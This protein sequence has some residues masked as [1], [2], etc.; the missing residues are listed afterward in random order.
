MKAIKM[1]GYEP[2]LYAASATS[3][4]ML[5]FGRFWAPDAFVAFGCRKKKIALLNALERVRG[6]K[7]S[8]FDVVLPLEA[9]MA[10]AKQEMRRPVVGIADCIIAAAKAYKIKGFY[11]PADFP[12]GLALA[13][14]KRRMPLIVGASPFFPKQMIKTEEELVLIRQANRVAAKGI[15]AAEAALLAAKIGP[16]R[17]LFLEKKPLTSE[18]LRGII[19]MACLSFGGQAECIA[20][21][22]DQACDP[23]AV[24]T[25]V[26]R[27]GELIIVDVFPRMKASGYYGDMT[28]TFLKGEASD[29]QR[30]L[31]KAVRTAQK[32]AMATVQAGVS[33]K[34]V[35]QAAATYFEEKGYK[36][37]TNQAVPEGFIHSTGHGVGLGLHEPLRISSQS[38]TILKAG[39]VVTL[40]PGLYYPGIGGVR[41]EDVVA[42][43]EKGFELL[44]SLHYKWEL[45]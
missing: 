43:T 22:G 36:T 1:K 39:M 3:A 23:H 21:G 8:E 27:A 28:R 2:L 17:K 37:T 11:V 45:N 7:E 9:W 12:V 10:R 35:H 30:G 31:I 24:G 20:A 19:E 16:G 25:G 5:Y 40:E 41:I 32:R 38:Q 26:L 6:E 15:L 29:A 44:S 34:V 33:G 13:L 4:E 42:V 14:K 18:R